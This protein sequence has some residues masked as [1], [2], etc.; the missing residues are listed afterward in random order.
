[1]KELRRYKTESGYIPFDE[2]MDS[3]DLSEQARIDAYL[4]RLA[5]GILKHSVMEF[6]SFVS[7]QDQAIEFILPK[8]ETR[9][10]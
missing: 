9:S 3:L 2:W 6:M 10:F 8:T 4:R 7:K 1:M 5:K